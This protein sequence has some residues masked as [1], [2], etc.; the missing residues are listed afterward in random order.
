MFGARVV[1]CETYE[2]STNSAVLTVTNPRDLPDAFDLIV[3][4]IRVVTKCR[5]VWRDL[6]RAGVLFHAQ[7]PA[8]SAPTGPT[9]VP[10][11]T[12][13]G[14]MGTATPRQHAEA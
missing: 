10:D 13:H 2:L 7:A 6:R 5:V 4:C 1:R 14:E 12:S 3:P 8:T 11:I 9:L